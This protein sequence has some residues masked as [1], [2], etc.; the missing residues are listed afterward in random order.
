[1]RFTDD[2]EAYL[3]GDA[4]CDSRKIRLL[5]TNSTF[6]VKLWDRTR[7]LEEMLR[8]KRVIHVG[9]VDHSEEQ[10]RRKW[11][12]GHWLHARIDAVAQRCLGVDI[13]VAGVEFV[14]REM[15]YQDV[16]CM[17]LLHDEAREIRGA[18][19]D[20]LLLGEIVEHV[21]DPVAFLSGLRERYAHCVDQ[22]LITVPNAFRFRNLRLVW[23]GVERI[24]TDHRYWFTP[25]T[26]A[27]VLHRAGYVMREFHL[28][29]LNPRSLKKRRKPRAWMK[30]FC[31]HRFPLSRDTIVALCWMA[32]S[33]VDIS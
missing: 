16:Y 17:D 7:L 12:Q 24:N 21:D 27:K 30:S 1:M 20:V 9:C 6:D 22:L 5:H 28:V 25:Y 19:W 14:R 26:V 13:D 2:V 11:Q 4:F 33:G 32:K 15:G 18:H 23:N 8:G 29:N 10:I 31:N 3:R